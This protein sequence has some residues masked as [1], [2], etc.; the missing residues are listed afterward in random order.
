MGAIPESSTM[1]KTRE[2]MIEK[3]QAPKFRYQAS[4]FLKASMCVHAASLAALFIPGAWPCAISAVAVNH[5]MLTGA[6]LWPRSKIL[7]KNWVT[8]PKLHNEQH[9][10]I[11]LDDG[12][13][14][15][16]TPS[17]LAILKEHGVQASFFCVGKQMEHY[18]NIVR[19]IIEQGHAV[20]NHSY[21]H[22]HSFSVWGAGKMSR[23]ITQNQ[24]LIENLTGRK[25][26]FFRPP[27]GLRNPFL[28]YVLQQQ[29]LQLAAWTRRGF[30][31][32]N[33]D[34][35]LVLKRLLKNLSARD[36]L[37][38]HDGNSAKQESGSAVILKV[39]PRLLNSIHS[40][41]LKCVRLDQA[42]H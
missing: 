27:A 14:P 12:P 34:E 25:P 7:G 33:A 21:S 1:A 36:I 6:G 31:T 35:A 11:T 40:Q 28:D 9:V 32:R 5:A 17:V 29:N 30:D 37:L 26:Q 22:A 20:E 23:D 10:A 15:E 19:Q 39:L 13:N 24:A 42:V 38:I 2:P 3:S 8:L 18:P 4:P 41:G 16:N